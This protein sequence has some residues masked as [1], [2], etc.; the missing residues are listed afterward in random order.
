MCKL[1]KRRICMPNCP[2]Y[3][4]QETTRCASCGEPLSVGDGFY[5]KNGFPYCESCL[6]FADA[7]TLVRIC[8]LSKREWLT[9]MGFEHETAEPKADYGRY[10][11]PV[12]N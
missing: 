5:R 9:Q 7:E 4:P 2:N 6:D 3:L 1:C 8:E 12:S 10:Y 11:D